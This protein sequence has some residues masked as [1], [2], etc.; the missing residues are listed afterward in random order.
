[1]CRKKDIVCKSIL[2]DQTYDAFRPGRRKQAQQGFRV[3]WNP[4]E[5]KDWKKIQR[6]MR[7]HIHS[8]R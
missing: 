6:F 8:K 5:Q 2:E 7:E 3:Y 1:L 4:E